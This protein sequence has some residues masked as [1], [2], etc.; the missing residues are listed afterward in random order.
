MDFAPRITR[1]PHTFYDLPVVMVVMTRHTAHLHTAI[2]HGLEL[3]REATYGF[4]A[5]VVTD[6][7]TGSGFSD[8]DWTV[9]HILG[10]RE[11]L[12]V[13]EGNW[14]PYAADHV[15]WAQNFYGASLVLAPETYDQVQHAILRV[16]ERFQAADKVLSTARDIAEERSS[17]PDGSVRPGLRGWWTELGESADVLV[18]AE[19]AAVL[20]L[21]VTRGALPGVLLGQ[22][23]AEVADFLTQADPAAYSTALLSWESHS[24]GVSSAADGERTS[25]SGDAEWEAGGDGS[26]IGAPTAGDAWGAAPGASADD[27]AEERNGAPRGERGEQRQA[28]RLQRWLHAAVLACSEELAA[29]GPA[30]WLESGAA[31]SEPDVTGPDVTGPGMTSPDLNAPD[32]A[33][34]SGNVPAAGPQ[35]LDGVIDLRSGFSQVT[36]RGEAALPA[37]YRVHMSY[38]RALDVQGEPSALPAMLNRLRQIH[39]M[40][41]A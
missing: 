26:G 17:A 3:V 24:A 9:E 34:V 2:L 25:T 31:V 12:A 30:L 4:R 27:G 6:S 15:L 8:V 36:D 5:V 10:E 22:A 21:R 13:R 14:L 38:G 28:E 18:V 11:W 32:A 23:G 37:A 35:P 7:A 16:G 33:D 40:S 1:R 39:L 29:G 20:R 41:Q 19:Q